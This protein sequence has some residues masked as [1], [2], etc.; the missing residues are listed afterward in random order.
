MTAFS[1]E[2]QA[3]FQKFTM[4]LAAFSFRTT[5][6]PDVLIDRLTDSRSPNNSSF[7]LIELAIVN[8]V[9]LCPGVVENA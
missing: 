6:Y 4:N 5:T 2:R 9:F 1:S 3:F 7:N 8:F